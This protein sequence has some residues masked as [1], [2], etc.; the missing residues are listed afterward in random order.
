[1]KTES[2]SARWFEKWTET[3]TAAQAGAGLRDIHRWLWSTWRQD[4][5]RIAAET[6]GELCIS[7]DDAMQQDVPHLFAGRPEDSNLL[8]VNINPGW[9][10]K[11][12]RIEEVIV[13]RSEE[14][15]WSF[16]RSLFTR[17]PVE[18][19]KMTWW[20]QMIGIAWRVLH[21]RAPAGKSAQEKRKWADERVSGWELLPLHSKSA[22]VLNRLATRPTGVMIR[23]SMRASLEFAVRCAAPITVVAS[24][25]G[26][27]LTVELATTEGWREVACG[28]KALPAGTRAFDANSRLVLAVP[29]QLVSNYSGTNFDEVAAAMRHLRARAEAARG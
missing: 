4:G 18:V 16:C 15:S 24:S 25:I 21:G 7:G 17:Y 19:G 14:A 28:A 12:N 23:A 27:A 10:P 22:G 1:M 3:L 9:D 8:F 2:V 29:R 20:S 11:R 6:N 13:K 26:T 5:S